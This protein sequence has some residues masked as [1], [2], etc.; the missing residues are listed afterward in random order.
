M[1]ISAWY[2][3]SEYTVERVLSDFQQAWTADER[4]LVPG[5]VSDWKTLAYSDHPYFITLQVRPSQA[6]RAEF[7][8]SVMDTRTVGKG[9]IS[10]FIRPPRAEQLSILRS[11]DD[12]VSSEVTVFSDESS[13]QTVLD[14]Y[15][16]HLP[17]NGWQI[18]MITT[19]PEALEA[20]DYMLHINK[21]NRAGQVALSRRQAGSTTITVNIAEAF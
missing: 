18:K 11:N 10:D 19:D 4:P 1:Q 12:G 2:G 9:D 7:T 15:K 3:R 16:L 21:E 20:H 13:L 17:S 8:L 5:E 14:F 6:A